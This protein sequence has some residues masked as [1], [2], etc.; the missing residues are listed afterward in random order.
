MQLFQDST[1]KI[2][3]NCRIGPNV[4]LGPDV[5]IEDGKRVSAN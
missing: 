2:G 1:T 4:T 5:V 3:N